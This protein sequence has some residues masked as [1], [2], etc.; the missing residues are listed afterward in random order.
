MKSIKSLIGIALI[1]LMLAT[2]TPSHA[3]PPVNFAKIEMITATHVDYC[4]NVSVEKISP[5]YFVCAATA[6]ILPS[7]PFTVA[8]KQPDNYI[9]KTLKFATLPYHVYTKPPN[10][11]AGAVGW[12]PAVNTFYK[13]IQI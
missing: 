13:Q 10:K 12:K 3:S 2:A 11:N 7:Q 1:G 8:D 9:I 4:F 6:V 5:V